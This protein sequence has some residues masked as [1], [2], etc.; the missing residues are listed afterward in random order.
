MSQEDKDMQNICTPNSIIDYSNEIIARYG[1]LDDFNWIKESVNKSLTKFQ[2][3]YK[4]IEDKPS[5][6]IIAYNALINHKSEIVCDINVWSMLAILVRLSAQLVQRDA[7]TSSQCID[8]SVGYNFIGSKS[9]TALKQLYESNRAYYVEM[10]G[11][12][13]MPEHTRA[14][15]ST[16][17]LFNSLDDCIVDW[18]L[19]PIHAKR[20][21]K[22][23]HYL[24]TE[25]V[26]K[27]ITKKCKAQRTAIQRWFD[28]VEENQ[29]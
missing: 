27:D 7:Y 18:Q 24:C 10:I 21:Y 3:L 4:Y 15:L 20:Q 11:T 14:W 1:M 28:I 17:P 5:S 12:L 26:Y 22:H 25:Y 23:A 6:I 2:A 19:D 29:V 16:I 13:D 8:I 9:M